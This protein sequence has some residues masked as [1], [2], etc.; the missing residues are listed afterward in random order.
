ML[1]KLLIFV[2]CLLFVTGKKLISWFCYVISE[3]VVLFQIETEIRKNTNLH[4]VSCTRTI[5]LHKNIKSI[6]ANLIL[7]KDL[8]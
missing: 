2:S 5:S 6:G 1:V 3:A 4:Y 7:K 8:L